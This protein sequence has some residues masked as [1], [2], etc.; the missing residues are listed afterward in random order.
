MELILQA[1]VEIPVEEEIVE[2][3]GYL[4]TGGTPKAVVEL[5][6]LL[7]RFAEFFF[8]VRLLE[9]FDE[10]P[11]HYV[12]FELVFLRSVPLNSPHQHLLVSELA[13]SCWEESWK[14]FWT[15]Y[16]SDSLGFSN[17]GHHLLEEVELTLVNAG[18]IRSSSLCGTYP[19]LIQLRALSSSMFIIIIAFISSLSCFSCGL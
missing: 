14:L 9:Q 8:P 5:M 15:Q 13:T 19:G 10:E 6:V 4:H 11:Y 7:S 3:N 12:S 2:L 18:R 17:F 16:A 1:I